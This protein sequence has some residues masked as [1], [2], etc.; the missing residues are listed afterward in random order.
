M[1]AD[2][3]PLICENLVGTGKRWADAP[4]DLWPGLPGDDAIPVVDSYSREPTGDEVAGLRS[5]APQT[6]LA[7]LIRRCYVAR[8]L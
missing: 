2:F 5:S 6:G 4:Q 1:N 3:C 8:T 7:G